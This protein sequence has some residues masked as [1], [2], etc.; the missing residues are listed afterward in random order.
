MEA[1]VRVHGDDAAGGDDDDTRILSA[2]CVREML[3]SCLG[4]D[5][6]NGDDNASPTSLMWNLM[7]KMVGRFALVLMVDVVF[8]IMSASC[9]PDVAD[10]CLRCSGL[11]S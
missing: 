5:I 10:A 3:V 9:Q 6:I 7:W 8:F 1:L 11:G 4:I 2:G